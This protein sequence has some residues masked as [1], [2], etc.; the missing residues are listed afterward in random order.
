MDLDDAPSV[1]SSSPSSLPYSG[2][3]IA[4][5]RSSTQPEL[6]NQ[7]L[8]SGLLRLYTTEAQTWIQPFFQGLAEESRAFV[9]VCVAIQGYMNDRQRGLSLLSMERVDHALQS[10]RDEIASRAKTLHVATTCAGLLMCTLLLLQGRP[11]TFQIH[12]MAD[13]YQLAS[14][15]PDTEH[16]HAK[17]HILE[18]M[19]IM[20]LPNVVLGRSK[21]PLG[22]WKRL[23]ERQ[24]SWQAGRPGGIELV[25]GLPRSLLDIFAG[26]LDNDLEYTETRLSRWPG[27]VGNYLQCHLWDSWRFAGIMEVR[28]RSRFERRKDTDHQPSS[29]VVMCQLMASM[30]ALYRASLIPRNQHILAKNGLI[31]PMLTAG[32]EVSQL[33]RH[34]EWKATID[35]I[36]EDFNRREDFNVAKVLFDLIDEAWTS[37]SDYFDVD[38]AA[39]QKGVEVAVF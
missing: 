21:P 17:C 13:L 6:F 4:P 33:Q 5:A 1:A 31:Y 8:S 14:E 29:E 9:H 39:L 20:D 25:S 18:V 28:R 35:E 37:G 12:L 36:R 11:W 10:F 23:R 30:D 15:M 7:F 3:Q 26:I 2:L 22:I 19:G 34:P 24:D 38:E 16:D 27:D 32:L